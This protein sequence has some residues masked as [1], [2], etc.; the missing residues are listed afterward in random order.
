MTAS[1]TFAP[2]CITA[3]QMSHST[4]FEVAAHLNMVAS[5]AEGDYKNDVENFTQLLVSAISNHSGQPLVKLG[6]VAQGAQWLMYAVQNSAS[7][8]EPP[9]MTAARE[10]V[11]TA[12][13]NALDKVSVQL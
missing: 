6:I 7:T 11:F 2:A 13:K 12:L 3:L 8:D 1:V 5:I 9:A 10:E 4:S